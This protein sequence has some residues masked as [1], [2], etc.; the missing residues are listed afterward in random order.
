MIRISLVA[1]V[2]LLFSAGTAAWFHMPLELGLAPTLVAFEF[3]RRWS[4]PDSNGP[5]DDAV[6]PTTKKKGRR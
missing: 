2:V 4:T 5:G 3:A 1:G 6:G